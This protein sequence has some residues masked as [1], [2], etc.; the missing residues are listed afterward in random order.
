VIAETMHQ[1]VVALYATKGM[2]DKDADATSG[3]IR[4]LLLLA[5]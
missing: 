2:L 5:Q 4:R 1:N 3:F